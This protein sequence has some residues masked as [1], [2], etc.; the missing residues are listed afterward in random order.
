MDPTQSLSENTTFAMS[1]AME[2][3][4]SYRFTL[5]RQAPYISE[6]NQGHVRMHVHIHYTVKLG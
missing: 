5:V 1:F 2:Y 3:P 4:Y 6:I